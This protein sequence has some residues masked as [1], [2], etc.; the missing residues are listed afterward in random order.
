MLQMSTAIIFYMSFWRDLLFCY[1]EII[2]K[3]K[4]VL[5]EFKLKKDDV[6]G[7]HGAA[8]CDNIIGSSRKKYKLSQRIFMVA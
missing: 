8:R 1:T 5:M 7:R 4:F 3:R 2:F 6:A